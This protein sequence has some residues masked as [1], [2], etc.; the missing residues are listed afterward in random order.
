[1]APDPSNFL[2]GRVFAK[3]MG[4]LKQRYDYVLIDTPPM[5]S[6]VDATIV[7]K[8]CDG[9]ILVIES[10]FVEDTVQRRK[11]SSSWKRVE[12]ICLELC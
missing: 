8:V 7:G 5:A 9:A 1:M 2:N 11:Q 6:V 4:E 3:L 10:G 12:R